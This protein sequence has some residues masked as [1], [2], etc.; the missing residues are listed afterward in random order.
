MN[1]QDEC[2]SFGV[3]RYYIAGKTYTDFVLDHIADDGVYLYQRN[4]YAVLSCQCG[5]IM[6]KIV[7][8]R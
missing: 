7:E 4:E 6:R 3:H 1:N 2:S 8:T 5:S